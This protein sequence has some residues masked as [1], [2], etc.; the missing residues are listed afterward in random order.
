MTKF[1]KEKKNSNDL[2]T[3]STSQTTQSTSKTK[4]NVMRTVILPPQNKQTA[5]IV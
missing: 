3:Q 4:E 1:F 5:L 2:T